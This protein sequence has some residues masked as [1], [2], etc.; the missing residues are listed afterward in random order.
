MDRGGKKLRIPHTFLINS[1]EFLMSI[2]T[3]IRPI[4]ASAKLVTFF[5]IGRYELST[6]LFLTIFVL[7]EIYSAAPIYK[8][9]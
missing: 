8:Y 5:S 3:H 7:H 1:G 2:P 6:F 4:D 9:D